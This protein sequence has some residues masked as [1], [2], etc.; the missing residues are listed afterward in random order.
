MDEALNG[1]MTDILADNCSEI[2]NDFNL[3]QNHLTNYKSHKKNLDCDCLNEKYQ[4][5]KKGDLLEYVKVL[6]KDKKRK[7][8]GKRNADDKLIFEITRLDRKKRGRK[9]I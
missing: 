6:D 1:K 8:L 4:H 9:P 2:T 5:M 3:F 7:I